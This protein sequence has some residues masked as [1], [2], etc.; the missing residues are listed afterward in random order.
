MKSITNDKERVSVTV[1]IPEH[2]LKQINATL[3]Q[4]D[5]PVSRNHW[6]I[7]AL[8][9]KLRRAGAGGVSNGAR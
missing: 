3:D 7:E 6:I 4:E 9:E 2:I 5:V 8:V 1:R